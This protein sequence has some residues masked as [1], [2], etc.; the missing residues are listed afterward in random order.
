MALRAEP[1]ERDAAARA[2]YSTLAVRRAALW[3]LLLSKLI[4]GWGVQ[5][6]IQWHVL[7]GRDSFWIPPHV[8]TYAGVT[9]AVFLSAGV[10][11]WETLSSPSPRVGDARIR[12]LGLWATRGFHLA[13]WGI[14]LTVLAA[15]IDDL[16]HRLFGLDVTLW[17]PPHL[18][19]ILGSAINT[20]AC[21]LIAREVYPQRPGP[22]AAALVIA[23]AMLYGNLHLVVDPSNLVAYRHGG[24][25][26]YTLAIL[27]AVVLPLALVTT[28]R[29]SGLRSAPVLILLV[30]IPTGMIGAR[31]AQAGFVLIEPTSVIEDEIAKDPASSIALAY[32]IARKNGTLP[33]RTGGMLHVFALLP[34][35]IMGA[36]DARYRPVRATLGYA[37]ALF[38]VLGFVLSHRPA[39]AP[40]APGAAETVVALG[41]ALTAGLIGGASARW[42]SDSLLASGESGRPSERATRPAA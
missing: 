4:A 39:M 30:V 8:M 25:L 38:A 42:L 37:V 6:D 18:L 41:L 16:W 29:V 33:G 9:L 35:A 27:S 32:T 2:E 21:L 40:M 23:G 13:A 19:G 17:S 31:I 34:A 36:L 14:G 26:F 15:P 5:W 3:G 20:I 24:V 12:I 11:V 1:L 28:A 22:R 7:I 10:L